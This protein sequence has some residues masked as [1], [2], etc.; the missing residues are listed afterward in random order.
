LGIWEGNWSTQRAA[1]TLGSNYF[2]WL[3]VQKPVNRITGVPLTTGKAPV[4]H[5]NSVNYKY[6]KQIVREADVLHP[7]VRQ[8]A[9]SHTLDSHALFNTQNQVALTEDRTYLLTFPHNLTTP[10]FR[11]TEELDM[12][13][14]TSA[15]VVMSG[16]WVQFSTYGETGPRNYIAMAPGGAYNTGLRIAVLGA[17]VGPSWTS[18]N[19]TWNS[20]GELISND[21]N[22]L[23]GNIYEGDDIAALGF[24]VSAVPNPAI[25]PTAFGYRLSGGTLPK[26]VSFDPATGAFFGTVEAMDYSQPTII[27]FTI[28]A[29]HNNSGLDAE[30]VDGEMQGFNSRDFYFRYIPG[31][32]RPTP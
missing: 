11:Y 25:T 24:A 17:D 12:I 10:R 20:D 29:M 27:R 19:P 22:N 31:Q 9:D 32:T 13:G 6:W 23:N 28:D 16:Q 3:L 4:V 26:G 15:D 7:S 21:T 5:V 2:N 8:S 18:V 1:D 14:I 30:G